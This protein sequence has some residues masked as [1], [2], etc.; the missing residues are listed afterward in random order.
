MF[1]LHVCLKAKINKNN[2]KIKNHLDA[3]IPALGMQKRVNICEFEAKKKR[4]REEGRGDFAAMHRGASCSLS[5]L[6]EVRRLG[7]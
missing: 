1:S 3:L 7:V 2:I 4:G 6:T 5:S